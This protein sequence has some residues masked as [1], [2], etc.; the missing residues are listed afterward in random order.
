MNIRELP[1]AEWGR[2]TGHEAL[3]GLPLPSPD[4]AVIY[5]AE[6][7]AGAIVG[8]HITQ[9]VVHVHAEP[10][11]VAPELRGTAAAY[12]LFSTS[13]R[14][15]DSTGVNG[16]YCFAGSPAISDYLTRLGATRL[17]QSLHYLCL[18][19][20]ASDV[21]PKKKTPSATKTSC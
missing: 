20:S 18:P 10:L 11:W 6:D 15:L 4:F 19:S 2:L 5:V 13:L 14:S 9:A 8:V 17:P 12:K 1:V 3:Q 16:V 21:P 7:A